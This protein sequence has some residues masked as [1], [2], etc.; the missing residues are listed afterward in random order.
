MSKVGNAGHSHLGELKGVLGVS[1]FRLGGVK[2]P[3]EVAPRL[4]NM[5]G[6]EPRVMEITLL[7]LSVSRLDSAIAI[8]VDPYRSEDSPT[9]AASGEPSASKK[10]GLLKLPNLVSEVSNEGFGF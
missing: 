6:W 5:W 1:S 3:A 8:L 7:L 9:S 2:L 4:K 10:T